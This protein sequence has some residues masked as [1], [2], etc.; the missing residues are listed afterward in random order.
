MTAAIPAVELV[1]V[2]KQYGNTPALHRVSFTVEPGE[3]VALLGPNGAGKT[4]TIS[5]LL[6]LRRPTTGTVRVFG[7]DPRTPA[8]RRR[9]CAMLQESGVPGPLR[10]IECLTLFAALYP[11]PRNVREMLSLAELEHRADAR[12]A[13]LSGGE[14]QRL[15]FALALVGNPDLLFLDEPTVA[16][17]VET[18]RKFWEV[19]RGLVRDG[20]TLVLTTH[21]LEEADALADRI[22]VVDRGHIV[23]QGSPDDIKSR[24]GGRCMRFRATNVTEE[25]LRGL[26]GT[27]RLTRDG[28]RWTLL[29]LQP[30]RALATLFA[31]GVA[32]ERLEVTDAGLEE[33]FVALTHHDSP[34]APRTGAHA[35]AA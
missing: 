29:T 28:D 35:E 13:T 11:A 2:G 12:V 24:V 10:V 21:Y 22:I 17:D 8:A 34:D 3:T 26:P 6:G 20:T 7:E 27:Q 25:R 31:D 16:L 32:V 19:M 4:T 5:L 1:D 23:A 15:Y 33:A 14:R 9:M 30:E 18:R